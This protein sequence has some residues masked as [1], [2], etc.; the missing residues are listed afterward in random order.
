[1]ADEWFM[2]RGHF[3]AGDSHQPTIWINQILIGV[4]KASGREKKKEKKYKTT[5]KVL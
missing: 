5:D 2:G 1:M 3:W 4:Q